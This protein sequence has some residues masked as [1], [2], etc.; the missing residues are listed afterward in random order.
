MGTGE[1]YQIGA[2]DPIFCGII[3]M[4]IV[5]SLYNSGF[6]FDIYNLNDRYGHNEFVESVLKS[7]R[8]NVL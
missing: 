7:S 3:K 5:G 2:L 6:I 4:D 1:L 8:Y